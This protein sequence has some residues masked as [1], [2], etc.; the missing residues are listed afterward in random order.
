MSTF[1][2]FDWLFPRRCLGCGKYGRYICENCLEKIDFQPKQRCAVC[3]GST[4]NGYTHARCKTNEVINGIWAMAG[5]R[6]VMRQA[7]RK[8]KYGLVRDLDEELAE[9]MTKRLPE[10]L[11]RFDGVIPVPLF[12]SRLRWRGFNQAE[13]LCKKLSGKFGLP[14]KNW[15]IK[16]SPTLPQAQIEMRSERMKNLAEIFRLRSEINVND[17]ENKKF[18]LIDDIATTGTTLR[19]AAVP[20]KRAGVKEVWGVVWAR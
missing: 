12:A 14:Y 1:N 7:V 19:Q 2:L 15:L 6:G 4:I 9:L 8:L 3:N 10:G 11:R 5:Y 18:L 20:L 13:I 16:V 17:V